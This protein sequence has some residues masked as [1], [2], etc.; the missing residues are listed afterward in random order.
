MQQYF[1]ELNNNISNS[2]I[3]KAMK[4]YACDNKVPILSDSGLE[5]L[6]QLVRLCKVK[7]VLEIGTAIAYTSSVIAL[8]DE[9]IVIDTIERNDQM[10]EE[11]MKNIEA[12]KLNERIRIFHADALEIDDSL[13]SS[14]YDLVFI[15]AA[16]A[17]YI[18]FFNKYSV[19]TKVGGI[20]VTD[21]LGFHGY[22]FQKE[23]IETKN[24]RN[25]TDK[26][27]NYN[28]W[29]SKNK[30]YRTVFYPVGD[31]MAISERIK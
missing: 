10:Y 1:D 26:I 13:L 8:E 19:L 22:V 3:I 7:K 24:L 17:Q 18:K 25:L 12:L 2:K 11:A 27:K 5:F 30:K 31:G 4:K 6:L 9:E 16:K 20:I 21:N 23:R 14:D 29:L 15:D 28:D